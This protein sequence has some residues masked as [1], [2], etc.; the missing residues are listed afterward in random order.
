MILVRQEIGEVLRDFRQQKGRTLRQVAS[1]A[2]VVMRVGY[3]EKVVGL[4]SSAASPDGR[5]SRRLARGGCGCVDVDPAAP[6]RRRVEEARDEAVRPQEVR[7]EDV[8]RPRPRE[9]CASYGARPRAS[10]TRVSVAT[11]F[12]SHVRPPSSEYD[13]SKRQESGVRG[14]MT[15]RT[16]IMRP[17]YSSWE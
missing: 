12:T 6:A 4:P 3:G 14:R 13:C 11:Q 8:A 1:R 7:L 2:S 5:F 16:R 9:A 10:S 17:S 15:K